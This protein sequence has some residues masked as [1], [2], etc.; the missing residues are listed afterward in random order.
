M[1]NL[2]RV[3]REIKTVGLYDLILQDVQK[4]LGIQKPTV[5]QI[6]EVLGSHPQILYDYKQTNVEYNLSNIHLRDIPLDG[7]EGECLQKAKKVNENLSVLRAIEKYTLDFAHSSTLVIIFSVE[8]FVLF[9]VQYF[10]VLLNL[11][12]YQWYIYGLF[13]LSIVAAWWYAK[14][15]QRKYGRESARFEKLY[16]ETLEILEALEES[17]CVKKETLWIHESDEHV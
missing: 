12:A 3:A 15:E 13:A 8:F 6:L 14:R 9:S 1:T 11:K 7:L 2:D 16:H 10:I 4:I 17:G 5:E